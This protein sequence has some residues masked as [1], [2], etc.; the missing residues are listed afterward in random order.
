MTPQK[1]KECIADRFDRWGT[2][3]ASQDATPSVV[4]G[5]GGPGNHRQDYEIVVTCPEEEDEAQII[6]QLE[7]ALTLLRHGRVHKL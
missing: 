6:V 5:L 2:F 7:A 4:L 1:I 3:L